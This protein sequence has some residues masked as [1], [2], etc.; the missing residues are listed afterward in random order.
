MPNSDDPLATR[1]VHRYVT[2]A[3]GIF[4]MIVAVLV[5]VS[6]DASSRV[7]ALLVA[8]V[9]AAL[10]IDAVLAAIRSKRAWVSR[11]GPLP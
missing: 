3:F 5:L 6:A 10:G 11:I 7:A 4:L 2:G 8:A 1:K 9:L